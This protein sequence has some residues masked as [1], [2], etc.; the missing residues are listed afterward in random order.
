MLRSLLVLV[1]VLA[2]SVPAGAVEKAVEKKA[3]KGQAAQLLAD[4]SYFAAQAIAADMIV[5]FSERGA[6]ARLISKQR[7]VSPIIAF[8]PY[9]SVRQRMALYWGVRP[10]LIP[11]IEHT[12]DRVEEAERKLKAEGLVKG[13]EKIVILSGTQVGQPGGTNLMK[14][15]EVR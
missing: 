4:I 2:L 7:P 14:L 8:T 3:V 10:S 15:H 6:T 13:G 11:Q 1:T 12:D 5:V 9:E